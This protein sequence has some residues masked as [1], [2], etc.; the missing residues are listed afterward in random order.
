MEGSKY[1]LKGGGTPAA[2]REYLE[3]RLQALSSLVRDLG[4]LTSGAR[5]DQLANS[6]RL[7]D[8]GSL[9]REFDSRRVL[10]AFDAVDQALMA[11]DRNMSPK[12]IADWLAVQL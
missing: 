9:A 8:L 2:E 12:V 7:E 1:L 4:I 3:L 10:R 11:L 6:D 5:A